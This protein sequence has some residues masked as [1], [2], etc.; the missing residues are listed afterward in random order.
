MDNNEERKKIGEMWRDAGLLER[1][2]D[3][4]REVIEARYGL[5]GEYQT[6][7]EIGNRLKITRER[8]RQIEG[9]AIF[10]LAGTRSGNR[11]RLPGYCSFSDLPQKHR[12]GLIARAVGTLNSVPM[13]EI[14]SKF[15]Y[16]N[17]GA[18][19][20]WQR[21]SLLRLGIG[22]NAQ[23]VCLLIREGIIDPQTRKR[24]ETNGAK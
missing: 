13:K 9:E 2:T 22:N 3:R 15:G 10:R 24:I 21:H 16:E 14:A 1:L 8:V 20:A 19:T 4:Q 6:L 23:L 12:E 7:E 11:P 17:A 18:F 5:R